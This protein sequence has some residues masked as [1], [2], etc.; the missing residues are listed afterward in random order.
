[1]EAGS[2]KDDL[3]GLSREEKNR[4]LY[5]RQKE[6]LDLFLQNGAISQTQ[7][8]KSLHDLGE[9]MGMETQEKQNPD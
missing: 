7:H 5:F 9:K 3:S 8:D 4:C 2:R 6:L 1:M